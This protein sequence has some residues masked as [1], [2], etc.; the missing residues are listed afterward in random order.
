MAKKKPARRQPPVAATSFGA[1][2]QAR[3]VALGLANMSEFCRQKGFDKGNHS[4]LESGQTLPPRERE[5]R[6]TLAQAIHVREGTS[7]WDAFN[8]LADAAIGQDS[9]HVA[10]RQVR[11]VRQAG[12]SARPNVW[13]TELHLQQWAESNDSI[14][15]LPQ[16]IRMLVRASVEEPQLVR[17]SKGEGVQ[18]HGWD[19]LVEVSRG[20]DFVPDGV[21]RWELS[22]EKTPKKKATR[23]F[24]KRTKEARDRGFDVSQ[25]TFVFVTP[26]KWDNDSKS[27]WCDERRALGIWRDVLVWDST[28]LEQ[29]LE[30]AP[31]VDHWIARRTGLKP[32]G[33]TDLSQHWE[34]LRGTT[35]SSLVPALFLAGREDEVKSLRTFFVLPDEPGAI[36]IPNDFD[37]R[38]VLPMRS[39][40]PIDVI[41]FAA[42][43]VASLHEDEREQIESRL[44]VVEKM[45]AW[46]DLCVSQ[47]RLVF[48]AHPRLSVDPESIAEATRHGHQVLLCSERF[49]GDR[50]SVVELPEPRRD[51]LEKALV[52]CGLD[53]SNA[54]K[55]VD[56]CGRSLTVL[57]RHPNF[58]RN[59]HTAIPAWAEPETA[60]TF[61]PLLLAGAWDDSNEAD[62]QVL[63]RLA[64]QPYHNVSSLAA[65]WLQKEDA[66]II[67]I[68]ST[69]SFLSREDSWNLLAPVLTSQD[70]DLFQAMA[71]EVLGSDDPKL[72]LPNEQRWQAV[73]YGKRQRFSN[74]LRNGIAET[75]ALLAAKSALLGQ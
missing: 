18:R 45:D 19:G 6:L 73:L 22:V 69:W 11:L 75:I 23:E 30:T 40:S 41:D 60:R 43:L 31:A 33:T 52:Q 68:Q 55:L 71:L 13:M 37:R 49:V 14:H 58:A 74:D 34:N 72:E 59:P 20:N 26:R 65:S 27:S 39:A 1:Y 64:D 29:W 7:E 42:A 36:A 63:A 15:A 21:S 62:Q 28:D 9:I 47:H 17:F 48:L 66:P 24:D 38:S 4:R 54:A 44:L 2:Y 57:K 53:E 70:L 8:A 10:K 3:R 5:R 32:D 16:L 35:A 50:S 67:H 51:E 56:Q 25:T 61:V 46:R 12:I